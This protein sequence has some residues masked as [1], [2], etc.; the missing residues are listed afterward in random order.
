MGKGINP[1][2]IL[3]PNEPKTFSRFLESQSFHDFRHFDYSNFE[4][5]HS[6]VIF[7]MILHP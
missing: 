3:Q 5:F 7:E 2:H 4:H 1:I 6:T